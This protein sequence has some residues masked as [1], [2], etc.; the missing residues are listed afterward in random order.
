LIKPLKVWR[1]IYIV[2]GAE[3]SHHYD[4]SVYLLDDGD[5]VLIDSGASKNFNRI[6]YNIEGLGLKPE[7][8]QAILVT[9]AHID[10]IGGLHQFQ[11]EYG[12]Q[13]IA[14]DLDA[15]AIESGTG[16]GAEAYGLPYL[17]CSVNVRLLGS[18]QS[19]RF[20]KYE[21]N[22]IHIP[23]HTHGS[24]AAYI[25]IDEKRVIF[26]QDIHGPYYREWGAD[27]VQARVS[28]QNLIELEAGILCEGHFGIYQP[29]E[30]V[31]EYIRKYLESI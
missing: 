13:V 31:Q 7:R 19:L 18:E 12:V 26:G 27:P 5:L 21:L 8:L 2:G 20:G 28:L 15:D 17:P 22:I 4:C 24:I 30:A 16:F 1:D 3:L 10:H 6:V 25:D 23:G 11:E 9:H 29:A 14:H